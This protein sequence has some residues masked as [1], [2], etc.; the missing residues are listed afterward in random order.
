VLGARVVP[1]IFQTLQI[2][3]SGENARPNTTYLAEVTIIRSITRKSL[4][5]TILVGVLCTPSPPALA[6]ATTTTTVIRF[7]A[8][9]NPPAPEILAAIEACVGEPVA[10]SGTI[11]MV[12]HETDNGS[13]GIDVS[14]IFTTQ[15]V[16]AVGQTTGTIYRSPGQFLMK[17]NTSGPPPL[18]FTQIFN[19]S[20]IG[21]AHS[22]AL[23][24]LFHIVINADGEIT[25]TVNTSSTT[26]K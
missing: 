21:P 11:Q 24:N 16:L 23:R 25:T 19:I 17:F 1:S 14:A 15:N 22:F 4:A 5:V 26:C 7:S 3:R 13:G 18:E 10:F 20:F 12:A 6:Q 2:H 9:D 8:A